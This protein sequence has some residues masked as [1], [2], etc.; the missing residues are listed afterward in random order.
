M[1]TQQ[2]EKLQVLDLIL[3]KNLMWISNAD[4]K[5]A[6]LFGV[7]SA[8]LGVLA[9]LIPTPD[10]LKICTSIPAGFSG[11]MLLLSI[12]F[13]VF[14]AFPRLKGTE[15]SIIYFGGIS[16]HKQQEYVNKVL[17][18]LGNEF[19]TDFAMQCHRNGEIA[20]TKYDLVSR[21]VICTVIALPAWLISIWLL[22]PLK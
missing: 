10:K 2:K 13:Q 19:L 1:T 7:N 6:I 15:K 5:A 16:S 21:S 22:Y 14:V 8:M 9:A 18:S 3:T 17:K 20:K 11:S 4:T 12:V